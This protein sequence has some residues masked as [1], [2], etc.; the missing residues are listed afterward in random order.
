MKLEPLVFSATVPITPSAAYDL[1]TSRM[2]TWWPLIDHSIYTVNA[3]FC[4][5]EPFVDGRIFERSSSG[6]EHE[7]GTV[8]VADKPH[9]LVMTW[10]PGGGRATE[11]EVTFAAAGTGTLVTLEHRKWENL[12]EAAVE[13]HNG[14]ANGWPYVF[15][16][17]FVQAAVAEN[18]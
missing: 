4:V 17:R 9:R 6:E 13:A 16:Q 5:I 11:V 8:L 18:R 1:F 7:W 15:G 2:A 12:A 10:H 14:Y 3:T